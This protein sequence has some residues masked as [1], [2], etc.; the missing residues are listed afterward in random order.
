MVE[1]TTVLIVHD[2][3]VVAVM[4]VGSVAALVATVS[5]YFFAPVTAPQLN[6]GV[7]KTPVAP[8]VGDRSAVAASPDCVCVVRDHFAEY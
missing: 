3:Q 2:G 8:F 7:V 1:V 4:L 6:V 5:Q